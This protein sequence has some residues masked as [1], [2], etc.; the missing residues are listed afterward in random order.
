MDAGGNIYIADSRANRVRKVTRTGKS[1]RWRETEWS[2][3]R[4][5]RRS[6]QCEP[7][8]SGKRGGGFYG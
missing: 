1:R 7:V 8:V 5:R 2:V 6:D 4:G 3:Y